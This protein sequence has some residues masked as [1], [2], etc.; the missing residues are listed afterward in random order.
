M[1][2][3]NN[4]EAKMTSR[5]SGVYFLTWNILQILFWFLNANWVVNRKHTKMPSLA[6]TS[7][8]V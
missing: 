5:R 2:N 4:K 8:L 1:F 6:F 3:V 7:G